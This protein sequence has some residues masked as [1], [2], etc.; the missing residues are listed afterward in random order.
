LVDQAPPGDDF[1]HEIK[2]D[3]YRMLARL[4]AGD[5]TLHTRGGNDWS[6][7]MPT[8][9]AALKATGIESAIFDGEV[10]VLN[11]QGVSNFRRCKIH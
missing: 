8:L 9:R 3:G 4:G 1:L 5:A 6:A 10:V 2:L 11:E 7:R